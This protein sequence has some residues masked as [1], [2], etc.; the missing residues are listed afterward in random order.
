MIG[1]ISIGTSLRETLKYCLGKERA[2]VLDYNL[3]DGDQQ[4][5]WEQMKEVREQNIVVKKESQHLSVSFA[6]EDPVDRAMLLKI[7]EECA[8]EMGFENHQYVVVQHHD[9]PHKHI[10]IVVNRVGMN[11]KT[12]SNSHNYRRMAGFCRRMEETFKLKKVLS[13]RRFQLPEHRHLP[14]SDERKIALKT[15]IT[16]ALWKAKNYEEFAQLI[17]AKGYRIEKG[18]GIVFCDKKYL[19]VKGSGVG[20]SLQKIEKILESKS[21]QQLQ[22]Q[23]IKKEQKKEEKRWLL[24]RKPYT[25]ILPKNNSQE[26][27][28]L[29][30]LTGIQPIEE[31]TH[32]VFK[33]K[34]Q[35]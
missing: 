29:V 5:I 23:L 11:G 1:K 26:K 33:K 14:R 7:A 4:E 30:M 3:C 8:R 20:Y 13:P 27:D 18:R 12:F 28:I 25:G 35:L 24:P 15:A 21:Q 6:K 2:E 22:K 32:H 34:K 10:H 19:W 9:T 31:N 16:N 17:Q